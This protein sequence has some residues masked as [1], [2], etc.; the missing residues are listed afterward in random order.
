MKLVF[1]CIPIK[2]V[3]AGVYAY[4]HVNAATQRVDADVIATMR[5]QRVSYTDTGVKQA[6]YAHTRTESVRQ[7]AL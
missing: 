1:A 7:C 2:H 5:V 6:A 4:I 3:I